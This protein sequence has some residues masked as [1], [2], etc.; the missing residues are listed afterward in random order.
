MPY[1][2]YTDGGTIGYGVAGVG[3]GLRLGW[4]L[5]DCSMDHIS[6]M[7]LQLQEEWDFMV[8]LECLEMLA[9]LMMQKEL[10]G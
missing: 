2:T 10:I 6:G 3:V 4:N 1:V 9:F 7:D 8:L 5:L